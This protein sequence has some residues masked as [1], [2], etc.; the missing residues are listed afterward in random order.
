M[1]QTKNNIRK[2]NILFFLLV[3]LCA[4]I[5]I[6][7]KT[8][9]DDNLNMRQVRY[10][11]G[12]TVNYE[13]SFYTDSPKFHTK[14]S[15]YEKY[16]GMDTENNMNSIM[17]TD[18]VKMQGYGNYEFK[19]DTNLFSF[20]DYC[21][22][23]DPAITMACAYRAGT[24][25]A[26]TWDYT[27]L[28]SYRD[29]SVNTSFF[30]YFWQNMSNSCP[31]FKDYQDD[32][33]FLNYTYPATQKIGINLAMMRN[34]SNDG[35]SIKEYLT[36]LTS[37]I[38]SITPQ[39]QVN[40]MTFGKGDVVPFLY[41]KDRNHANLDV[42]H[43]SEALMDIAKYAYVALIEGWCT[44]PTPYHLWENEY[45]WLFGNYEPENLDYD[46][47]TLHQ[48]Y[49][50]TYQ[51]YCKDKGRKGN[52]L[53][54]STIEHIIESDYSIEQ[55]LEATEYYIRGIFS[56]LGIETDFKETM[57]RNEL[58]AKYMMEH[59]SFDETIKDYNVTIKFMTENLQ[60]GTHEE[61]NTHT[62]VTSDFQVLEFPYTSNQRFLNH[63]DEDGISDGAELGNE[64]WINVTE[65]VKKTY[66]DAIRSGQPHKATFEAQ[67]EDIIEKNGAYTDF[68]GNKVYGSVKWN[69]DKTK[70]LYRVYDYKSNPKL[71]DTD[72]D[73]LNDNADSKPIDNKFKGNSNGIGRVEY[74][75]D[76]RWFM[77]NNKKY[78]DELAVM[79]LIMSNLADGN[80]VSTDQASGDIR[81]YL[82]SIGFS[83]IQNI[84]EGSDNIYI[85]KKT[86]QYYDNKK[87]V[88]GVFLGKCDKWYS[89]IIKY[90]ENQKI[91]NIN[92]AYKESLESYIIRIINKTNLLSSSDCSYWVAGY[93]VGG[94]IASELSS[95][96]VDIGKEVYCYTFGA[97]NTRDKQ[98]AK[99]EIKNV[100]NEDDFFVKYVTGTKPG[101][102]YG[103]SIYEDLMYQYRDLTRDS[104]Y[105][106]NYIFT[107]FLLKVYNETE[108]LQ[109][110][111]ENDTN[112]AN[113][114]LENY[115]RTFNQITNQN[116]IENYADL[117]IL[118]DKWR[119]GNEQAHSI[120][121]YYVLAKS[122]TGFDLLD[123]D[124]EK[125]KY[126]ARHDKEMVFAFTGIE[127]D[128]ILRRISEEDID[129]FK[130][131]LIIEF[132]FDDVI[133]DGNGK[134]I[135]FMVD[136]YKNMLEKEKSLSLYEINRDYLKILG[137]TVYNGFEWEQTADMIKNE[138]EIKS[139]LRNYLKY[140]YA[141]DE[142]NEAIEMIFGRIKQQH[143][144]CIVQNKNDFAHLCATLCAELYDDERDDKGSTM[145][146]IIISRLEGYN[147]IGDLPANAGW[148]GDV[149]GTNGKKPSFGQDDY[150]SDLD[151]V[152]LAHLIDET[153]N[154]LFR[155]M[156]DYY[157][158]IYTNLDGPYVYGD[159]N[160]AN[161]FI[162]E[163]YVENTIERY[164]NELYLIHLLYKDFDTLTAFQMYYDS[165]GL[166][167]IDAMRQAFSREKI[168]NP[169]TQ[170]NEVQ[171]IYSDIINRLNIYDNFYE[172]LKSNNNLYDKHIYNYEE[173]P[174][175]GS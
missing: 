47:E 171:V 17:A 29:S 72:F 66:E 142:L 27:K 126:Y 86:I 58:M 166:S 167:W 164:R 33:F 157:D 45:N 170:A 44:L 114:I 152:N 100:R 52:N 162:N 116:D 64:K 106:G 9:A 76:F 136:L 50:E 138:T 96:L 110:T 80:T 92:T 161:I 148:V 67:V 89:D 43:D 77:T 21:Y 175:G 30:K 173:Y 115:F 48:W 60:R 141:G 134:V 1:K 74:N 53:L 40:G 46:L 4:I 26:N 37:Y 8:I 68:N 70:V 144:T 132:G 82:T 36:C 10:Q 28:M 123:G 51:R 169:D 122:L 75:Q 35:E 71:N 165:I 24:T 130:K 90:K 59:S 93:D 39:A 12:S 156:N 172:N 109:I 151:A 7:I 85:A 120:K 56:D 34:L 155:I 160:R 119:K 111:N 127:N 149:C 143:N 135:D 163:H 23:K 112:E 61:Q 81:T 139:V 174:D 2:M 94:S 168:I 57:A 159:I 32:F 49:D 117:T 15:G 129:D 88:I 103:A 133:G 41:F 55:Q 65:F 73:G 128:D 54:G 121:S 87:D 6:M 95:K 83:N 11:L 84:G 79:S 16:K 118:L 124:G 22:S 14:A 145:Y 69:D 19:P 150:R 3:S 18:M 99:N 38:F 42:R 108:F 140:S 147:G 91:Q 97:F 98:E 25:E 31:N 78:N 104:D 137:S 125:Q 146:S 20:I 13:F 101:Q 158:G 154:N 62:V 5:F 153:N 113:R 105:K 63:S 107:N 131:Y 102:N